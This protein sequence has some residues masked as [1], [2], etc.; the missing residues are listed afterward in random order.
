MKSALIIFVKNPVHG[1]V[2]TRIAK[3]LGDEN[4]LKVYKKLLSHTNAV[5]QDLPVD[6]YVFYLDYL[7][8]DDLW[9]NNIYYKQ[10]QRGFD[11]GERMKNA[12]CS[13]FKKKYGSVIIIGSDCYALTNTMIFSAFALLKVNDFVIGPAVD[14][15]YYLL[16]MNQFFP[17]IFEGKRW[18]HPTV[19]TE[20]IKQIKTLDLSVSFLRTLTDIDTEKDIT[21]SY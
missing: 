16:G 21:F 6:K 19:L 4:A 5:T 15:G 2:K 8:N 13:L 3:T 1:K 17:Q 7:N 14:G 12:F 11:L 20:T 9:C 10:L 18:S